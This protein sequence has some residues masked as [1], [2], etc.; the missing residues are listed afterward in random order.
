M[1]VGPGG[2]IGNFAFRFTIE[3]LFFQTISLSHTKHSLF[4]TENFFESFHCLWL[5][6]QTGNIADNALEFPEKRGRTGG[7]KGAP[8][9][10]DLLSSTMIKKQIILMSMQND[11]DDWWID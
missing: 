8:S 6:L 11:D 7:K 9:T 5:I 2:F 4:F 3:V 1:W 10:L